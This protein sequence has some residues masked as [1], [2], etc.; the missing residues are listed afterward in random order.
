MHFATLLPWLLTSIL[1]GPPKTWILFLPLLSPGY[2]VSIFKTADNSQN[3]PIHLRPV[4]MDLATVLPHK[5]SKV[6]HFIKQKIWQI[7]LFWSF[8]CRWIGLMCTT[9]CKKIGLQ[10]KNFQFISRRSSLRID[11]R[12]CVSFLFTPYKTYNFSSW[13]FTIQNSRGFL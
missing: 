11:C 1:L 13:R 4:D 9:A 8:G 10:T 7:L 6:C 2:S 3:R 5:M 12:A